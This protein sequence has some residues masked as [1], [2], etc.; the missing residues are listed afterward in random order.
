MAI[1]PDTAA[2]RLVIHYNTARARPEIIKRVFGI[3]A[4]FDRVTLE[5]DVTLGVA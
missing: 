1:H 5:L 3:D 2:A 4:A